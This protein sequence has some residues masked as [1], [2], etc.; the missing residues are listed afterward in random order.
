MRGGGAQQ[1]NYDTA[2]G[3]AGEASSGINSAFRGV[4]VTYHQKACGRKGKMILLS[5]EP[6]LQ[7]GRKGGNHDSGLLLY[8]A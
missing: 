2:G 7:G 8:L 6:A 3:G 5:E 4:N 1:L